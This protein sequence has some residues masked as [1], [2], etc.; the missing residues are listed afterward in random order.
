MGYEAH[1]LVTHSDVA[2][3]IIPVGFNKF[4][5][6]SMASEAPSLIGIA[7]SLNDIHLIEDADFAFLPANAS[8]ALLETLEIRG[9]R[10]ISLEEFRPAGERRHRH[11]P[12]PQYRGGNPDPTIPRPTPPIAGP[13]DWR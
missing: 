2:V 4:K 12:I 11:Q 5:G 13:V 8:P 3:D 7:D 6:L 1:V 9:R 10:V